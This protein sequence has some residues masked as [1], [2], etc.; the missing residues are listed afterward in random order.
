MATKVQRTLGYCWPGSDVVGLPGAAI[1]HRRS[2]QN[3]GDGAEDRALAY[4][5][6]AGL[7]LVGAIIGWRGPRAR[8]AEVD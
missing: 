4:L 8:G 5:L 3:Q 6:D 7:T 1:W 2:Q